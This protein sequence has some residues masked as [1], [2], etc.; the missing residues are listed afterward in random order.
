METNVLYQAV[1][2]NIARF[3]SSFRLQITKDKLNNLSR[4][5]FVTLNN[6]VKTEK[7]SRIKYLSYAFTEKRVSMLSIFLNSEKAIK[8][9]IQII[10]AFLEMRKLLLSN[11]SR[12]SEIR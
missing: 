7:K 1:K 6:D 12:C 10:D 4:P 5:K 11:F 9:S 2:R 8:V 3:L